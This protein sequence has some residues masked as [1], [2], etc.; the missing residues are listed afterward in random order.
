[1]P[2]AHFAALAPEGCSCRGVS[3][4]L[5]SSWCPFYAGGWEVHD[6]PDCGFGCVRNP[7]GGTFECSGC[8]IE[9]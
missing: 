6:C 7:G 3:L 2:D 9:F 5:H 1:M 4:G 8:G